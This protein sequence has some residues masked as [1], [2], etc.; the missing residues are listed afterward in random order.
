M[1]T[2]ERRKRNDSCQ[3]DP[4]IS[5]QTQPAAYVKKLGERVRGQGTKV[6]TRRSRGGKLPEKAERCIKKERAVKNTG[7]KQTRTRRGCIMKIKGR[8]RGMDV[9]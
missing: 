7:K 3:Q 4:P 9:Q 2:S 1:Q 6:D 8:I 5:K